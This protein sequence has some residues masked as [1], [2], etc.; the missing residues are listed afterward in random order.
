[1]CYKM[2]VDRGSYSVPNKTNDFLIVIA[3][4]PDQNVQEK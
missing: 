1:M 2:S 4:I 3:T